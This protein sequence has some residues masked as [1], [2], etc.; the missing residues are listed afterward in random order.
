MKVSWM[1]K[2]TNK[3]ILAMVDESRELMNT[4]DRCQRSWIGHVLRGELMLPEV[5]EGSK[6]RGD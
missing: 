4:I 1:D 3:E 6:S 2:K 5:M